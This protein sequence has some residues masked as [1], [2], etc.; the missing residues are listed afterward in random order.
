MN[1]GTRNGQVISVEI[2][3]TP[4][5][6][7]TVFAAGRDEFHVGTQDAA[8]FR[9]HAGDGSLRRIV[10]TG[11]ALVAVTDRHLQAM[12]DRMLE[13]M[14]EQRREQAR[15]EGP[16]NQPHGDVVPPYAAFI[17]D[18]TGNLWV[19]DY[20]DPLSTPGRWTV[21]GEDGGVLARIALPERFL[22]FDI[23]ADWILG[24]ELDDLDVEHM[25][26]YPIVRN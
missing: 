15:A 5:S 12:F 21:Y 8:E 24:R 13:R 20:D 6:K 4:Y 10:R 7:S 17:T 2:R 1:I 23:G 9:T 14:P 16:G 26:L 3:A 18:R 19:S 25:R 11:R 22:P